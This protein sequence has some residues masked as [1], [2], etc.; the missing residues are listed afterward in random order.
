VKRGLLKNGFTRLAGGLSVEPSGRPRLSSIADAQSALSSPKCS[1]K[2][3]PSQTSKS[4][5]QQPPRVWLLLLALAAC[6]ESQVL[7][8]EIART[9]DPLLRPAT[10]GATRLRLQVT[11]AESGASAFVEGPADAEALEIVDFPDARFSAVLESQDQDGNVVGFARLAERGVEEE[12]FRLA[13]RRN[14]AFVIHQDDPVPGEPGRTVRAIDVV[15]RTVEARIQIG[16]PGSVAR[17]ITAW[18]ARGFLIAEQRGAQGRAGLLDAEDLSYESIDLDHVPD[19][20]LG[21]ADGTIGLAAGGGQLSFLDLEAM[22]VVGAPILVGG[23]VLD[24]AIDPGGRSALVA[25]DLSPP[26]LVSVDLVRQQAESSSVL[27]D[28]A[29]LAVDPVARVAY[30]TSSASP[31]VAAVDLASGRSVQLEGALSMPGGLASWSAVLQ[32]FVTASDAGPRSALLGFSVLGRTSLPGQ[33]SGFDDVRAVLM[34]G[35]GRHG[36]VVAGG[37]AGGDPGLTLLR[38]SFGALPE[39]SNT[40]YPEDSLEGIRYRPRGAAILHGD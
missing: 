26:G 20:V 39:A 15:R 27:P 40:L 34:D 31:R 37:E 11:G 6:G 22:E 14:L 38:A 23:R 18:G 29:G 30:V 35:S 9:E 19:L 36:L 21:P 2:S 7:R 24:A 10:G 13:L 1:T 28:A 25:I 33:R 3:L 8:F 4:V 32:G 16:Q 12:P 17:G 5:L